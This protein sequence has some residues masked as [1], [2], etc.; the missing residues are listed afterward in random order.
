MDVKSLLYWSKIYF[1]NIFSAG[2][3]IQGLLKADTEFVRSQV[4]FLIVTE[5]KL[6]LVSDIDFYSDIALC[7]QLKQ[8]NTMMKW[9]IILYL[10]YDFYYC[11]KFIFLYFARHNIYKVE[12]IPGSKHRLRKTK[13]KNIQLPGKTYAL[14]RKNNLMCNV[15][16]NK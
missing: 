15:I 1:F 14:N 5:P 13:Y 7:M 6:N 3:A 16:H 12:R 8:P 4:D 10:L 9:V 2:I 11:T